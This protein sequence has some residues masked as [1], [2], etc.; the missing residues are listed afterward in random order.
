MASALSRATAS[1]VNGARR[2]AAARGVAAAPRHWGRSGSGAPRRAAAATA[3]P[4]TAAVAAPRRAPRC[5]SQVGA[6]VTETA[7]DAPAP[8]KLPP[9]P[10][11]D[12]NAPHLLVD[13]V[14]DVAARLSRGD[15]VYLHCWGGRGRAGTV[16]ACLLARLYGLSADEA[17]ERVQRAFD[18]RR[19]E[20]RRSPETEEQRRLVRAYAAQLGQQSGP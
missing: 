16:G 5:A 10:P 11:L 8:A 12:V 3:A 17:L 20:G 4:F 14:E 18:T 9:L 13:M 1:G 7:A 15:R 2:I 19:D 6:A